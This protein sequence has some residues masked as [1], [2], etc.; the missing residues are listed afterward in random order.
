MNTP[1]SFSSLPARTALT[2]QIAPRTSTDREVW[3]TDVCQ[4]IA[5]SRVKLVMIRAPAGFGKTTAMVQARSRLDHANVQTVW[6]TLDRADNDVPRFINSLCAAVAQSGFDE[7]PSATPLE[8]VKV[9]SR[10]VTAFTLFLDDFEKLV[11]PAVTGLVRDLIEHLPRNGQILIGTRAQPDLG[12]ARLRVQGELLEIDTEDLRFTP[13]EAQQLFQLRLENPLS[14]DD[15]RRL[16]QKTEGWAAALSLAAIS[17]ARH[18]VHSDFIARFSGSHRDVAAYLAEDVLAQQPPDIREFLLRTSILRQLNPSLCQALN[19]GLDANC[20]LDRLVAMNLFLTPVDGK[21]RTWRYHSMFADYLSSQLCRELPD[22]VVRLHLT[23][24]GWYEEQQRPV[25]AIDHAIEGGDAPYA[26]S[27]LAQHVD[28]FLEQGRMR[29]LARWFDALQPHELA[30]HPRLQVIAIWAM[31][32]THGPWQAMELL[33]RSGCADSPDPLVRAHVNGQRPML[34]AMMDRYED[35]YAIGQQCL[36]NL[37][38]LSAFA[39]GVLCNSMGHIVSVLGQHREAQRLLDS[40]RRVQHAGVFMRMYTES[41]EGLVDLQL[42]RMREAAARFR[43]AVGSTRALTYNFTSGNAWAGVLYASSVYEAGD[44]EQAEHLLNVYLPLARDVGLPDHIIMGYRMRSR[45]AFQRGDVDQS[46]RYLTEFEYLGVERQLPRVVA[47]ARLERA[48]LLLLQGHADLSHEELN[49]A[50]DAEQ[51]QRVARLSLPANDVEDIV[52]GRARWEIAFGDPSAALTRLERALHEAQRAARYSRRLKLQLL[53]A[54]ALQA[55]TDV[56]A[57]V[58]MAAPVLRHACQE[59]FLRFI[60]DEGPALVPLLEQCR[61]LTQG[62]SGQRD[63]PI[64][65]E[66]I[67]RLLQAFGPLHTAQA[68]PKRTLPCGRGALLEPLTRKELRA[69]QLLAEGYSNAAMAENLFVSDSTVRTHLRNINS[70]LNANNRTEAVAI[71]RKLGLM[72]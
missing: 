8:I 26:L 38:T 17:L 44:I 67:Q 61:P 13:Q 66:Y 14:A 41:T 21:Q 15:V 10:D 55:S 36:E 2:G 24:S 37:P 64:L 72:H 22:E 6:V 35:G 51:W 49:R 65:G 69:L 54:L 25:P 70:K 56:V 1:V 23:A 43:I 9:L 18:G 3:R 40:A 46:L 39:D 5:S 16:H 53:T 27:L 32:F 42:G 20:I 28:H 45:I 47:T 57:A 62:R 48:R 52:I 31:A 60:L 58:D 63:D 7:I 68:E 29:L 4:R 71:A 34:L 33:D 12:I 19:P 30:S 50:E 59:D 11:E